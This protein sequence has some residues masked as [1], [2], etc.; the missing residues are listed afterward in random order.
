M[1][2]TLHGTG[3]RAHALC[4]LPWW[5]E[6]QTGKQ[7]LQ[8]RILLQRKGDLGV[9][10]THLNHF[11]CVR[12]SHLLKSFAFAHLCPQADLTYANFTYALEGSSVKILESVMTEKEK[13][14][15]EEVSTQAFV[16]ICIRVF[17]ECWNSIS[18]RCMAGY[19]RDCSGR[20]WWHVN[21]ALQIQA[22]V[23]CSDDLVC[24]R[25]I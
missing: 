21:S 2:S 5:F 18:M 4:I 17:I 11:S 19:D 13:L 12:V 25:Q 23:R 10:T 15:K 8:R 3:P 14:L 24:R 7:F 9:W 22:W 1:I 16:F 20:S 6:E